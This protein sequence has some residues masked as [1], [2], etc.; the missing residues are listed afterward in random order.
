MKPMDSALDRLFRA[1]R[2]LHVAN[3]A[4]AMPA[5]LETRILAHWRSAARSEIERSLTLVFKRGLVFAALLMLLSI[6]WSFELPQEPANE[7]TLAHYQF[8]L[9]LMP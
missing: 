6:G 4:S 3:P 5:Y 7:V 1:V 2:P 8:R 9:D